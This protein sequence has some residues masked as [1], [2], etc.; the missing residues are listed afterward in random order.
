MP[1]SRPRDLMATIMEGGLPDRI[2]YSLFAPKAFWDRLADGLQC[3]PAQVYHLDNGDRDV[4]PRS[5][6][7]PPWDLPWDNPLDN[8]EEEQFLRERFA[9]YLPREKIAG[10]RV[11]ECGSITVPGSSYHL[12]RMI[13]PLRHAAGLNEIDNFPWPDVRE[14]WRWEGLE[15]EARDILSQGYWLEGGV[16]SLF[17]SCW[18]LRSQEQ[19]LMDT[20]INPEFAARLLDRMTADL[21]YKAA[22]LARMGVDTLGCADDMGHQRQLF[23]RPDMLRKWILSRW[24]RIIAAAKAVKPDVKIDFHTDGRSEEMIPDLLAIGVTAI[25]PVQP[26]CD[27]P[28][29]LKR[30]FG[31]RLVLKGTLSSRVLTFG[32]PDDVKAE[33][34]TRMDTAKRF[35]GML[36]TPNNCPD[37]NTSPANFKAFLDACEEY[38]RLN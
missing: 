10:L 3:P 9:K 7:K 37:V 20:Y 30:R 4:S 26:E 8:E 16:G 38:G 23:M 14:D 32:A 31:P 36:I 24:E 2:P 33:I 34:K 5:R 15:D 1:V 35:G 27:D 19:L 17:E 13:Y 21:E 25:N 28:E 22:R 11:S 18:Y 12:R 6:G 29:H